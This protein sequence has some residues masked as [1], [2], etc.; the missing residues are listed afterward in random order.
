MWIT[1]D[2]A[3][4]LPLLRQLYDRIKQLIL[5][6]ELVAGAKLPSSRALSAELS[7]SRNT[8]LEAYDQLLAEGYLETRHGSGTVVARGITAL[9]RPGG[10]E[11]AENGKAEL[12]EHS[13]PPSSRNKVPSSDEPPDIVN[14]RSGIPALE[15]FPQQEWARTYQRSCAALP[16]SAFRYCEPAGVWELR[17]AI[18]RYLFRSRGIRCNPRRVMITSGS[19]QGLAVFS[20]LLSRALAQPLATRLPTNLV[21][22][23]ATDPDTRLFTLSATQ[24]V[25]HLATDTHLDRRHY[26]QNSGGHRTERAAVLVEDPVHRGLLEVVARSGYR[27]VGVKVDDHGLDTSLLEPLA[28][29][30]LR[31]DG[32]G[33]SGPN[34]LD[35]GNTE[36]TPHSSR[37]AYIYT[38][39]SH[40]YPMG[41]I[42]P[43]QRRM[44]LLDFAHKANCY[45]VE[46]DYD[47]EF[48]YEGLPV[49]SLYEL[50]PERVVYLGSFSK[51]LAPALRLGFALLPEALLEAW[52]PEKM[53]LDVH[54]DA[55]SQYALA[56]FINN[57]GLE[58]HIWKMKKLYKR[59]REHLV[60]TL[61]HYFQDS[62]EIK[63]QAAGLHVVA[64]FSGIQFTDPLLRDLLEHGVKVVPVEKY[65]LNGNGEHSHQII[66]GYA[67]LS[68]EEITRGV[69]ILSERLKTNG[70]LMPTPH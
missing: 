24:L 35:S 42:L 3:S 33:S 4:E 21:T 52:K 23:L 63:G 66:L 11:F 29:G 61:S 65:S 20:Q 14:F 60:K 13:E 46:D 31:P 32:L 30:T 6:G 25:T 37:I 53:Y 48:R 67:H 19:T 28:L 39:P 55:L 34:A 9:D 59:K 8:V 5:H 43:I 16:A 58:K 27:V 56:A 49:S 40:Q 15:E 44:A 45:V 64:G 7:V 68:L 36:H 57:G 70:P 18:T 51:I 1:L 22:D 38:T 2:A 69:R 41:G 50:D 47:S 54:T 17:E 62:F 10:A 26:P 12:P